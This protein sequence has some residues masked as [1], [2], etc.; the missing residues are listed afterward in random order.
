MTV[1]ALDDHAAAFYRHFGFEPT[2]L[3][4]D[5]L[6]VPLHTVRKVLWPDG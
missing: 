5:T 2:E 1:E 3:A 4:P 6:M